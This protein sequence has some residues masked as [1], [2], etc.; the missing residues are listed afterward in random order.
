MT[1]HNIITPEV[2]LHPGLVHFQ[3][4]YKAN[5]TLRVCLDPKDLN[6][7]IIC[8]H[9]RAPIFEDIKHKLAGLTKYYKLDLKNGFWSIHLTYNLS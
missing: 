4:S 9:Q 6:K 8:E 3:Y 5:E 2:Q 7:A 1:V